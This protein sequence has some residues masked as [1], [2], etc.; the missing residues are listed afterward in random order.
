MKNEIRKNRYVKSHVLTAFFSASL[1][2]F[3]LW[4]INLSNVELTNNEL[5]I[6]GVVN[7]FF[8]AITIHSLYFYQKQRLQQKENN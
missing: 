2:L 8:I 1:V 4:T 6:H 7:M 5:L 3:D